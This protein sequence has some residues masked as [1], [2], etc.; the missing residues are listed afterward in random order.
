M[1]YDKTCISCGKLF[2]TQ[3]K[4]RK[5]CSSDCG[6]IQG[7]NEK[8]FYIC[9]HCG[10]PF[11]R[12]NAFRMKFCSKDCQTDASRLKAEE[13]N[14]RKLPKEKKYHHVC[15]VC[16]SEFLTSYPLN[17]YCCDE[18]AKEG[19]LRLKR[20]QDEDIYVPRTFICKECAIEVVTEYKNKHN[21][22]CC[23][24]CMDKYNRRIE[25]RTERHKT[26]MKRYKQ[27]RENQ[28]RES[29]VEDVSYS[30]IYKRD[31]GICLICGLP[32]LYDK[33][34]DHSWNA[35]IDHIV[36]LSKSGSHSMSNCQ[37]AHRI[38]N[39]LKS[40]DDSEGFSISWSDKA[41]ENN[42]WAQK[43]QSYIDLMS[44]I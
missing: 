35:T 14:K 40:D 3:D 22:F 34:I 26:Y 38:C 37:L 41:K 13:R 42:Y 5:C 44:N 32:V 8:K 4:N 9:Q 33:Q 23:Q 31:Q 24:T 39:S 28:I 18:C 17:I 30:E 21:T 29:F 25:H 36:P 12:P 27:N 10:E 20:A 7:R 19:N 11:W 1:N 15:P 6:L 43:Y 2:I 16:E